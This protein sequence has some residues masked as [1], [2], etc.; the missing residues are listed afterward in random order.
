M[1]IITMP[2]KGCE[3]MVKT[4]IERLSEKMGIVFASA[5]E[6]P[7]EQPEEVIEYDE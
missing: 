6:I 1:K 5:E 7:N 2:K 3:K 4:K